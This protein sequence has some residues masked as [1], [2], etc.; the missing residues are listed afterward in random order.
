MVFIF[1]VGAVNA[2]ILNQTDEISVD[3]EDI[4]IDV[5][6]P[7]KTFTDLNN[8]ISVSTGEL[9]ITNDYV[10]SIQKDRDMPVEFKLLARI[11]QSMETI[12]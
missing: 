2:Q 1:S 11:S 10:F 4:V 9:N 12:M 3:D 8:D 7:A 6:A 5:N